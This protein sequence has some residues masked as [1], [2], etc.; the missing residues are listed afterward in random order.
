MGGRIKSNG[1]PLKLSI[2]IESE[3]PSRITI[4]KNGFFLDSITVES[5]PGIPHVAEYIDSNPLPGYYRFEL[6]DVKNNPTFRGI[7]WRDF[8]TIQALSNPIWVE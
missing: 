1:K 8:T 3:K 6:H 2:S 4:I 5:E 7:E